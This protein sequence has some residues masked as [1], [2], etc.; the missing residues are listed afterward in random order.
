ME[1]TADDIREG[2]VR[3]ASAATGR[4]GN[5]DTIDIDFIYQNEYKLS[6]SFATER[7]FLPVKTRNFRSDGTLFRTVSITE[8]KAVTGEDGAT[9]YYPI[10]GQWLVYD[11][12]GAEV[13]S[14]ILIE[15]V[16]ESIVINE[17]LDD[18]VFKLSRDDVKGVYFADFNFEIP[19]SDPSGDD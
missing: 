1:S 5:L 3:V 19:E 6:V 10:K 14:S 15:V 12:T 11:K 7:A 16:P 9:F 13:V 18:G 2:K 4:A 17:D 8:I